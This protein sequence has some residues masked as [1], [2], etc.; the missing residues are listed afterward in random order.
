M[1]PPAPRAEG[2][3]RRGSV[4][5]LARAPGTRPHVSP[6]SRLLRALRRALR[7]EASGVVLLLGDDRDVRSLNRRF[8]S[9]DRTTD[10]LSF[11]AD[12][13][14]EPGCPHLGEI[15][16]SMPR[17][18]R[19][20]RRAAWPL[21]SE[22]ALLITHGFLHLLGY[23]HETDDGAMHRLEALLL[24]R[25]AG[26]TLDDRRTPWGDVAAGAQDAKPGKRRTDDHRTA[27]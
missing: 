20:A 27:G 13:P 22:M 26:V 14:L 7:R 8:R 24:R 4:V 9:V 6:S 2:R 21:R 12:G 10:V 19:Q 16:I 23:D 18:A 15:A 25:V 5:V 17:A 3:R 11:P 1:K